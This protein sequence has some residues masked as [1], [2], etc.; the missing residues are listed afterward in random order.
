MST[1]VKLKIEQGL[2][3]RVSAQQFPLEE[4]DGYAGKVTEEHDGGDMAQVPSEVDLLQTHGDDS[5][6][7]PDDEHAATHTGTVG[8]Q[9]PE[10]AV[11][12]EG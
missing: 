12:N 2:S 10:D 1:F 3:R 6:S 5:G 11:L 8:E 7:W 4:D 9:E